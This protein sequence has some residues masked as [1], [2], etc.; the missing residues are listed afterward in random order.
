MSLI[1]R[2]PWPGEEQR[3]EIQL[4]VKSTPGDMKSDS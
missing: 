2:T 1:N 4:C 3:E